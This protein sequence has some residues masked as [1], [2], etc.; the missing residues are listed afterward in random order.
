MI[1]IYILLKQVRNIWDPNR[2]EFLFVYRPKNKND[3]EKCTGILLFAE[4]P[5]DYP[6]RRKYR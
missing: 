6:P 3:R 2:T 4:C 5:D 1:T